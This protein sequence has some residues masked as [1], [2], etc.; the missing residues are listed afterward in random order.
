MEYQPEPSSNKRRYGKYCKK[1]KTRYFCKFCKSWLC[2]GHI[3]ACCIVTE[4]FLFFFIFIWVV[5]AF[6]ASTMS[7]TYIL[8]CYDPLYLNL[9]INCFVWYTLDGFLPVILSLTKSVK[10]LSLQRMMWVY[11]GM[12]Y[13]FPQF[14]L[15]A[16]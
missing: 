15:T 7:S 8:F 3:T 16:L 1:R 6:S 13:V 14:L 11:N 9:L 12:W 4:Y 10:I 2:I 5:V